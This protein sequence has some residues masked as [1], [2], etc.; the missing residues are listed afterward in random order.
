MRCHAADRHPITGGAPG[1]KDEDL[2]KSLLSRPTP[3][4][5][6]VTTGTRERWIA[7]RH[8]P[9]QERFASGAQHESPENSEREPGKSNHKRVH[10]HTLDYYEEHHE[11]AD[12]RRNPMQ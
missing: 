10:P 2:E 1:K 12:R 7:G 5:H 6:R 9:L 8:T 4:L 11:Y 3:G